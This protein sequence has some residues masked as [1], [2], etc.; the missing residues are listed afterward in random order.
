MR[1]NLEV[2]HIGAWAM[3]LLAGQSRLI[4]EVLAGLRP[5]HRSNVIFDVETGNLYIPI[6]K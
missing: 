1:N 3:M 4:N 5:P 2:L 6:N